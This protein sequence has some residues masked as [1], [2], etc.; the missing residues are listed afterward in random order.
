MT[1]ANDAGNWHVVVASLPAGMKKPEPKS[2]HCGG[3][4]WTW[5]HPGPVSLLGGGVDVAQVIDRVQVQP[6]VPSLAQCSHDGAHVDQP[7]VRSAGSEVGQA[8]A[9]LMR[10]VD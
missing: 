1:P 8:A 7:M 9:A 10:P 2:S 4:T 3:L 6:P 5:M